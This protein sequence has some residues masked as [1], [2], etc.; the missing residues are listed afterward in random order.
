MAN[1]QDDPVSS[2][3]DRFG[4]SSG[5]DP[6]QSYISTYQEPDDPVGSYLS[7]YGE[8]PSIV[9]RAGGLL[10]G[11]GQFAK[12]A[13][14]GLGDVAVRTA[15]E[16]LNLPDR[17]LRNIQRKTEAPFIGAPQEDPGPTVFGRAAE[18]LQEEYERQAEP[19]TPES[20]AG[21]VGRGAG[22]IVGE[23]AK[24]MLG[25][26]AI[27]AGV[28]LRA[29]PEVA[30]GAGIGAR[31]SR[32][33]GEALK[34]AVALAPIDLAVT[35]L[36]PENSMA[37]A[38]A[39][40]LEDKAPGLSRWLERTAANPLTRFGF[41][42][43]T[44]LVGDVALRGVLATGRGAVRSATDPLGI[45]QAVRGGLEEGAGQAMGAGPP[46]A[47]VDRAPVRYDDAGVTPEARVEEPQIGGPGE[48]IDEVSARRVDMPEDLRADLNMIHEEQQWRR[49]VQQRG[50]V[51][52]HEG[53]EWVVVRPG[54][55]VEGTMGKRGIRIR[56]ADGEEK[57]VPGPLD[58]E[59]TGRTVEPPELEPLYS[60]EIRE[61]A[62]ASRRASQGR[63]RETEPP[64]PDLMEP[65]PR[66]EAEG[67]T[68]TG[69]LRGPHADLSDEEL[70]A[71]WQRYQRGGARTTQRAEEST[72]E[73]AV[74]YVD[75]SGEAHAG[76][77]GGNIGEDW[78]TNARGLQTQVDARIRGVERE[79][80]KRGLT[81]PEDIYEGVGRSDVR[82]DYG[83]GGRLWNN[84]DL[85]GR[86]GENLR[87]MDDG[88][89]A[90]EIRETVEAW[91][92]DRQS[93]GLNERIALLFEEA[94]RRGKDELLDAF[95]AATPELVGI[96]ART[97]SGAAVGA[98]L[99]S[100]EGGALGGAMSGAVIAGYG[101][102]VIRVLR[103]M[104]ERGA[105]D[106]FGEG[107]ERVRQ[108]DMLEGRGP[109]G[110]SEAL[111]E[112]RATV[113]SLEG[114]IQR[115]DASVEEARRYN[116]ARSL[117]RRAE[118][119]GLDADEVRARQEEPGEPDVE[120][121]D[122]FEEGAGR[123]FAGVTREEFLGD[124]TITSDR[125]AADL[126]PRPGKTIQEPAEPFMGGEFTVHRSEGDNYHRYVVMDG[127]T[128]VAMYDGS[129]L[130]VA[131]EY[132]G[133]GIA[134]ELVYDF[135]T[136]HPEVPPADTRT[137]AAQRVQEKV[138][139]RIQR[140]RSGE[141][142]F[143]TP[144]VTRG[145]AA[146]GAGAA[147]G[148]A[149]DEENR[150]RGAAI[151]TA[152]GFGAE[153]AGTRL[154][155]R[156]TESLTPAEIRHLEN[157][158]V[159]EVV[160]TVSDGSARLPDTKTVADKIK[161]F[162]RWLRYKGVRTEAPMERFEQAVTGP[163]AASTELRNELA[164]ARGWLP[165]AFSH[166]EERL[167]PV[168]EAV[169][170]APT[171]V[172]ALLKAERGLELERFGK[173]TS[174]EQLRAWRETVDELG[175]IPEVRSGAEQVREYYRDLLDQK[176]EA[177]VL[178]REQYDAIVERGEFYIP[179]LPEDV[180]EFQVAGAGGG[181]YAPNRGTGVRRMSDALNEATTVDPVDQA[182]ID[183]YETFQRT[184][185]QRVA[186]VI[187]DLVERHPEEASE[188][189]ERLPKRPE[190]TEGR[191]VVEAIVDGE[192]RY[193][194]VSDRD[195]YESW[196]N[197]NKPMQST[198]LKASNAMRRFMQG[199][200]TGHP[201]FA[202][203]N[204]IR[205]FMVS[206]VQ[207]SS[208][209]IPSA[210]RAAATGGAGAVVGGTL[211]QEDPLAGALAGASVALGGAGALHATEHLGR[212]I[213]ALND[214]LGPEL[215][216]GLM[217]G[218]GG[219]LSAEEDES[220]FLRFLAGMGIGAAGGRGA[221]L[222]GMGGDRAIYR[223]F[224]RE[225][226]S[227][228]GFYAKNIKQ[229]K[230]MRQELL[231]EGVTPQDFLNPRSWWDAVQYV[232]RAVET[233]PRLA[234]YKHLRG[235]GGSVGDAI[236]EARDLSLDF[237]VK[238]GSRALQGLTKTVP[239]MNP[240]IQGFDK[241]VRLMKDP[242]TSAVAAGTILAPTIGLWML[243]KD[244]EEYQNR[245]IYE[246]NTYWLI[247]KGGD[248]G[249]FFRVPKP[250]EIGFIY[251]SIPERALDYLY[252]KD[253]ERLQFALQD[254]WGQYGPASVV[255]PPMPVGPLYEATRGEH[256]YDPFRRRTVNPYP[257]KEIPPEMQYDERTSTLGVKLGGALGVSPSK[258]DY[259]VEGMTGTLGS[260][261]LE[262]SS[263]AARRL[264]MDDRAA[265]MERSRPVFSRMHT[266]PTQLTEPELAFR[267][268]W[269]KSERAYN[270]LREIVQS[271]D[272][273]DAREFARENSEELAR[274][275]EMKTMA[276]VISNVWDVRSAIYD[277]QEMSDEEK[278]R[279]LAGINRRLA[280]VLSEMQQ[281][282]GFQIPGGRGE[283]VAAPP[284]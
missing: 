116:D 98:A 195:L 62:A 25:G 103:G 178:T 35:S 52:R 200:V 80:E 249:G 87:A 71:L 147:T 264:G 258:V 68:T 228:F 175:N 261:A 265:P 280:R 59:P 231:K 215:T 212:T 150:L 90:G 72:I 82:G 21:M 58:I 151:G 48:L 124:P 105:L 281:G 155:G 2:Y 216:A 186:N 128:P 174:G 135:R 221:R 115:G 54:E 218:T 183:T 198:L 201:A 99:G 94:S 184:A 271:G 3:L 5:P 154:F 100:E 34:D 144:G 219:A 158:S 268:K 67:E 91:S 79:M 194:E 185:K 10:R 60:P 46:Q 30:R 156:R 74:R 29:A 225:G 230:R 244:N 210:G 133:R 42:A 163:E 53:D 112:A 206:G 251:S 204:G 190:R 196:S 205:D 45:E 168:L 47:V 13:Y 141:S 172:N 282:G 125:N 41:E 122:M 24:Y 56:R 110:M 214:I 120:T 131:P 7:Q 267:R 176:L 51:V 134:T 177:G 126:E 33:V 187:G 272:I 40:M 26:G 246:K 143:T 130:V 55:P 234:R 167:T 269:Q 83:A 153:R 23:G 276:G 86:A 283:A 102:H 274:Y 88:N 213:S 182:V 28:G 188:F 217:A 119:R 226:G 275:E 1:G 149:L 18:G 242:Q 257:W 259:V 207:Y 254:M 37:G 279:K 256:G 209:A 107:A 22:N 49:A 92:Q 250:F 140:E 157:P 159:R 165:Q 152:V 43:G 4:P 117:L 248:E 16:A 106:L 170:E 142:G 263:R 114:K 239:F 14:H 118:G 270:G 64:P 236:F 162:G 96:L 241:L 127:D 253:P 278:R 199:G 69:R 70:T 38:G 277:S 252:T 97:A 160:E 76:L 237:S 19:T 220:E 164:R 139:D 197:F 109:Q 247:P 224:R 123:P 132:R 145:I 111:N 229:A 89:L 9:E 75:D 136:R 85:V 101:P 8:S 243:N 39:M 238:P 146:G 169:Q 12:Q 284:N 235:R 93:G 222:L 77:G 203:V 189:I 262:Q 57:V 161:G 44:G 78:R 266:S 211:N 95:G 171:L 11:A 27:R 223:E 129:S 66:M 232:S 191:N 20:T 227:G 36:G 202:L 260:A 255:A 113:S 181:R 166:L 81:P 17:A 273:E 193:Y 121:R 208:R 148:A 179:F 245:P 32:G 104:D 65:S 192:R 180:A 61:A 15:R 50:A 173:E 108:A 84:K 6:V 137:R 73:S 31:V 240:A 63:Y 138:W 233:A